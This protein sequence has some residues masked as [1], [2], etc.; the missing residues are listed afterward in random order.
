MK[1]T[2]EGSNVMGTVNDRG[3]SKGTSKDLAIGFGS[4]YRAPKTWD[5]QAHDE[6]WWVTVEHQTR[7]THTTSRTA[8]WR[9]YRGMAAVESIE[10]LAAEVSR[11]P[12][13]A[14]NHGWGNDVRVTDLQ[15]RPARLPALP[16]ETTQASEGRGRPTKD[17]RRAP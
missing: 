7:A 16:K 5:G 3:G 1:Q 14:G 9:R 17:G 11:S 13:L 12:Y 2:W 6:G 15:A 10:M 8:G 4:L